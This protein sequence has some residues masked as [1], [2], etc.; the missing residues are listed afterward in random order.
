MKEF[1]SFHPDRRGLDFKDLDQDFPD[2][3]YEILFNDLYTEI[4]ALVHS[5]FLPGG[6]PV[7]AQTS[8][9]LREYP[10][11]FLRYVELVAHPNT[12]AGQWDLLLRDGN[13]RVNLL[14]A[15][16]FRVLD[17]KVFS[18]LLFGAGGMHDETL[19]KSD[20]ALIIAE[21]V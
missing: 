16:I 1:R 9:W 15:I 10:E 2:E 6:K 11:E 12:R 7:V 13:E 18:S 20:T 14:T 3:Y 5:A 19:E 21:G 4:F 8:P 17:R